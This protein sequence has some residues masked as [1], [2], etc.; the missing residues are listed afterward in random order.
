MTADELSRIMAPTLVILGDDD[1]LTVEHAATMAAT[2][3]DAQLAVV[4]GTDHGLL[5]QKPDLV[6]RLFLDFLADE[7]AP[8]LMK[9]GN[10]SPTVA[11]A[12]SIGAD[13]S[14]DEEQRLRKLLLLTAAYLIFPLAIVWGGVYALAG[15]LGA[16]LIPLDLRG[17]I[18]RRASASSRW[19][20][21][22]G[23]SASASS[24]STSSCRSC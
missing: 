16:S 1:V 9:L 12:L 22:T 4:P 11:R 20:E 17:A 23:G 8:K 14:D 24:R 2:L 10:P 18:G 3:P 7:Q 19:C 15:A 5:F 13:P 6:S 21:R